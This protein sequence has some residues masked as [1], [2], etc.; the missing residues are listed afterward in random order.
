MIGALGV[1]SSSGRHVRSELPPKPDGYYPDDYQQEETTDRTGENYTEI[2]ENRFVKALDRPFSTF[3]IDVDTASYTIARSYLEEGMEVPPEVVRIEEFVNYFTYDYPEPDDEHPFSVTTE[4]AQCPWNFS[5]KLM[6]VGIQGKHVDI[7]DAP[8]ANVVF[9]IDVSGSMRNDLRLVKRSLDFLIDSLR[10]EDQVAIVVY[11]GASGLV[12]DSTPGN[13][14]EKIRAAVEDLEAG[15]STAGAAGIN[16]A[17][18]IAQDNFIQNGNNRV[19][20]I[21]DGDFNV[22]VSSEQQLKRLIEKKRES[23]VFLSCLGVGRGNY[24]DAKMEQLADNGN[25]N[26]SYI[27]RLSEAK[28]VFKEEFTSTILTIAKDVKVQ[29]EFNPAFVK[30]YRLL[31]YENRRLAREDFDDDKKDAG[32]LGSG[33]SVTVLCEIVPAD[34]KLDTESGKY[35]QTELTTEAME[36]G[37]AGTLRL[38]YKEPDGKVSKLIETSLPYAPHSFEEASDSLRFASAVVEFALLLRKS[39]FAGSAD[40]EHALEIARSCTGFDPWGRRAE[41]LDMII[42]HIALTR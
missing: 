6:L 11:A 18:K 16:L 23:G 25:G 39:D 15:G 33:H 7:S 14:K 5:N 38:R 22:G 10:P 24:Q 12:L 41:F 29:L 26:Y 35:V 27:D 17:Y 42:S 19:V 31:G 37:E 3:G 8:R 40:A 20:L 28:R 34:G 32:E 2:R 4:M 1:G 9:L 30:R 21:T 13:E 36:S